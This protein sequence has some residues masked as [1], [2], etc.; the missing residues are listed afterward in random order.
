MYHIFAYT[1]VKR[2][3]YSLFVGIKLSLSQQNR[4][5]NLNATNLYEKAQ[6]IAFERWE[7]WIFDQIDEKARK[8]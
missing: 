7:G 3:F 8:R 1:F 4:S 5:T 6:H 2:Y